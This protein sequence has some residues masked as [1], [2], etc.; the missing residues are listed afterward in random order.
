MKFS[1]NFNLIYYRTS[2]PTSIWKR[3]HCFPS[4]LNYLNVAIVERQ[5][6][7]I[8]IVNSTMRGLHAMNTHHYS[9]TVALRMK[10]DG[11]NL[12]LIGCC[13]SAQVWYVGPGFSLLFSV[14]MMMMWCDDVL[15]CIQ[16]TL[17]NAISAFN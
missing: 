14:T 17:W 3:F 13:E 15:N 1:V 5:L 11:R 8:L 2:T 12:L 9:P 6:I 7:I 16:C 4:P 10:Y